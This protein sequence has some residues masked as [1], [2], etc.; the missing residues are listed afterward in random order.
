M[1]PA[2]RILVV[3]ARHEFSEEN[4]YVVHVLAD[5]WR[6]RGIAV[7]FTDRLAEPM[8]PDV[9]VFPHLDV[10]LTPPRLA[11]VLSRCARVVNRAVVDIS[12]RRISR[13]LVA[14]PGD[15]HGQVIVKT[16][17]NFGGRPEF[18]LMEAGGGEPL[19]KLKAMLRLDWTV[20]AM[21]TPEKYP[22]YPN[23]RAVPPAVWKNPRL[24]VEKFLPEREGDLYCLRQYDDP[25]SSEFYTR[26]LSPDPRVKSGEVVSREVLDSTP[27]AVRAFREELGFDYGKFD[28]VMHGDQ[29]V[30]FDVNRTFS[31]NPDSKA[32]S[33]SALML[34]LADGIDP[35]LG[36]E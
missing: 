35:L 12:K 18:R 34:K 1:V 13:Q 15:Y 29:P 5:E 24:V 11:A 33:A 28:Y 3:R 31:Y 9:L 20:S 36:R 32:G 7:D 8:G 25:G 19:E 6:R 27:A 14:S 16:N 30:V 2:A 17:L 10:T 23:P 21:V 22:I 4:R 26:A